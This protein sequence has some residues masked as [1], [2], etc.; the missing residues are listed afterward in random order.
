[1]ANNSLLT[2]VYN[3]YLMTYAPHTQKSDAKL[4][5][6]KKS[7]LRSVCN[8]IAKMNKEAPLYI[9]DRSEESRNFAVSAKE[10]AR[11]LQRTIL[12]TTGNA[13]NALFDTKVAFSSDE[14]V[15]TATFIGDHSAE[16]EAPTLEVEVQS[17]A[18]PQVNLGWSLEKDALEMTPGEYSFDI[19]IGGMGY[20]FQ[21]SVGEEDT[22]F[23][24]QKKLSRLINHANIGLEST[25]VEGEDNTSALRIQSTKVG[26]SMGQTG[27]LFTIS[28]DKTSKQ[29]GSVDYFG[30][31]YIAKEAANAH[32]LVNGEESSASSNHFTI[33]KTY[34]VQLNGVSP[35]PGQGVT[36][37]L[38]PNTE[39]LQDSVRTL[40]GGYNDFLKA[41]DQFKNGQNRSE[42]LTQEVKN[43]SKFFGSDLDAIG[44]SRGED[45]T[46]SV[47][48]TKLR[49]AAEG[50]DM[51]ELFQPVQ[52]FTKALY[53]KTESVAL[54]PLN[55]INK[56]IVAY[57]NP[58]HNFN[59]PYVTSNYTGFLF[60]SY[61]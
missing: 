46:L 23:D 25:V 20:E 12:S 18:S 32:F 16:D 42:R 61:C 1:M 7:E 6:H 49:Q 19:N 15:L 56:T 10:G 38:K 51:K 52:D 14:N 45:G 57:K 2:A 26:V 36:I 28:D 24:I 29:S 60:N 30:I 27:P 40:I 34:E 44:V 48:D 9:L 17:L 53:R 13:Q 37:G 39:A 54:D 59:S 43:I 3:Q 55:Y 5:S 31:D 33:A 58:G 11:D 8:T 4:D 22:N 47:D 50:E 41:I 21:Y 35:E